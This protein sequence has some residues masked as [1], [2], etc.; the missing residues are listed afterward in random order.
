MTV[1]SDILLPG[2]NVPVA[3]IHSEQHE[4]PPSLS[5]A[6]QSPGRGR[7]GQVNPTTGE[8]AVLLS[9][10]ARSFLGKLPSLC[11]VS[12]TWSQLSNGSTYNYSTL[13]L[14]KIDTHAVKTVLPIL[15]LK[16]C[17]M[18]CWAAVAPTLLCDSEKKHQRLCSVL[19]G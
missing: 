11:P 10:S 2:W 4:Q 18:W 17:E 9:Y 14:C 3:L 13:Q 8:A 6:A 7:S 19:C 15:N 1:I 16:R 12:Y 5:T